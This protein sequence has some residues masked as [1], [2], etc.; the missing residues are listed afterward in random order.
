MAYLRRDFLI[1]SSYRL[2]AFWQVLGV[3]TMIALIYFTGSAIDGRSSL[4]KEQNGDYVAFIFLGLAFMDVFMQG[5][6]ALPRAINDNQRAGT[7]EPMLLAPVGATQLMGS[8]WIF[9][10]AFSLFR[11]SLFVLFGVLVLGYWHSANLLAVLVVFIPAIITFVAMGA[12]SAAFMLL[13][14]QGDPVLIAFTALTAVLGGAV[15]PVDALPGW[16]QPFAA[17]IPLTH[18][19][20]GIRQGFDGSS[21]VDVAPQVGILS[22]MAVVLL[23]PA[24][25]A[26]QWS[27]NRAKRE[28]SLGE[29]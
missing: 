19:L 15:F 1:W 11:M 20:S 21:V 12:F 14:K 8:L 22:M 16:I 27:L 28:G 4:V 18:A 25:L 3:F 23:P 26:F 10:F 13:V 17:L 6:G 9:R 24:M 29:Y 5:L 7:L 2:A